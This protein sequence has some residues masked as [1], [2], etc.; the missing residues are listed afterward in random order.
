M[1]DQIAEEL[2]GDEISRRHAE[3]TLRIITEGTAAATGGDF[4]TSLV[5]HLAKALHTRYAFVAECTDET[6]TEV[7]T[8]AFWSTDRL[9]EDITFRVRGT[10]CEKVI[11]GDVCCY[12]QSLQSLFPEDTGLVRLRAESYL[13]VPLYGSTGKVLG[14]LVV[15]DDKPMADSISRDIPVLRIFAARAGAELERKYAEE[16]L[17]S[18]EQRQ[19]MLLEINNAVVTKLTREDLFQAIC[20]A[21][22]RVVTF[23]RVA[24][25]L[26]EPESN[27]LRLVTYAGPYRREDYTPIGRALALDDSA[28]GM[29]FTGKKPVLRTDLEQEQKTSSD[30][31]AYGH[32]FRSLCALPLIVRGKSIGAVTV[33]S[34]TRFQYRQSDA[35]FLMDIANQI[36]IAIDNMRSYD[37]LRRLSGELGALLDVNRAISQHLER[38]ALFGALAGCL[39]DLLPTDRFGIELPIAD[40]KL[41][42]HLL[43]PQ[44]G[45][46]QHTEPHVMLAAG[47]ACNWSL[48]T[49]QWLVTAT[50][51]ELR[52]RFPIT[53]EVMAR[54]GME[55]L[56]T[57]PLLIGESCHGVL[58]CMAAAKQAY[59]D[60]LPQGLLQKVAPAVAVALDNCLAHEEVRSL[61]DRLAAENVYLQEEIKTEYNFEEIIGKSAPLRQ[62]LRKIEQV[63]PAETTVLIQGETGTGKELLAR[64]IHNLSPRKGRP[65]VKVNC[66]AIPAG[67]VESELFG[68]EKGAFTGALQRREGRFELADGG[69]IFLDEVSELPLDIQT[70]LLRVLQEGEFE[71]VGSSKTTKVNVRLIAATNRDLKEAVK[72][73]GFRSDLFYR[74]S[75]F[76]IRVPPLKE[77]KADIPL[78]V[79]F[80]I[81]R[82]A[83]KLGKNI[84]GVSNDTME[85]L[86][87]YPWPG[88]IRELQNLIERAVVLSDG[89]VLKIDDAMLGMESG[90][91][92]GGPIALEDVERAHIIRTLMET[93]WVIHGN[94]GAA[95]ILGINP[96]TLRSRMLKLGIKRNDR[97]L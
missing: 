21:M 60:D 53:F 41:Q 87:K 5:R 62:V 13:G 4:F 20:E 24:L 74:L 91:E 56:C 78:L 67:L 81:S 38:D 77:R 54:E 12:P 57:I 19:R 59:G 69:T 65:L 82:F 44:D 95:N 18:S 70:K 31:R 40:G 17:R 29:A 47:T 76:P 84:Q 51:D 66:G 43:S 9:A 52:E 88:N 45:L 11:G 30:K 68:H 55:S 22:T 75:V 26:H 79:S 71:R 37:D 6:R 63:A 80:F 92:S 97:R 89:P 14:H 27:V 61:R 15:I 48:Q 96:S 7:R 49:R 73:D 90:V 94:R 25:T 10:P 93:N 33:G 64:A 16:A 83:K 32:G 1:G 8:L 46:S 23:D 72:T 35:D 28:A 50:R 58:F 2:A 86:T 39:Q 34:L 36:A 85:R 42:G 3:E